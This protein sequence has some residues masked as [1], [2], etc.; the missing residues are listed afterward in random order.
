MEGRTNHM[1]SNYRA[2]K[3]V[4]VIKEMSPFLNNKTQQ[5]IS[6]PLK[7]RATQL[8]PQS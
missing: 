6:L 1:I 3:E 7:G 8:G 2:A 4:I 5:L